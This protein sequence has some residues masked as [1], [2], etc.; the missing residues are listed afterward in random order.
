VTPTKKATT[1]ATTR[2]ATTKKATAKSTSTRS[3]YPD[4][5]RALETFVADVDGDPMIVHQGEVVSGRH[6]VVRGH[7]SLFEVADVRVDHE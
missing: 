7:E 2:K 5:L 6:A 3:A 1:K 4:K